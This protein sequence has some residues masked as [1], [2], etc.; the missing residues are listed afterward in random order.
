MDLHIYMSTII[1]CL[2]VIRKHYSRIGLKTVDDPKM[3]LDTSIS[4][5]SK[6]RGFIKT[7]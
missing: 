7:N 3:E 5:I 1:K 6:K 4:H 2:E